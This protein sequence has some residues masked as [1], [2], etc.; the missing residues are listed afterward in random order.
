M[1]TAREAVSEE[2]SW[3]NA[4]HEGQVVAM[5]LPMGLTVSRMA[6]RKRGA[7]VLCP[8]ICSEQNKTTVENE[9]VP[10]ATQ[11]YQ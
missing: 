10:E 11:P 4:L 1:V 3:S 8:F 7:F 6:V 9:N 5:N 2:V